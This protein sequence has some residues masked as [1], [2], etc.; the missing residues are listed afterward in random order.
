[1]MLHECERHR[2]LQKH[3]RHD[4]D[5][6][7]ALVEPLRQQLGEAARRASP[8]QADLRQPTQTAECGSFPH[9]SA[10]SSISRPPSRLQIGRIG[11][12]LFD[13]APQSIDQDID[14][15]L[16]CR[17]PRSRQRLARNDRAGIGAEQ[18][19]HLALAFGDADRLVAGAQLSALERECEASEAHDGRL[20]AADRC[21]PRASKHRA[22]PQEQ[23]ARLK[24]LGQIVVDA[25]FQAAYAILRFAARR[26]HQDWHLRPPAQ[27]GGEIEAILA[28]HHDVQHDDVERQSVE[29]PAGLGR[30]RRDRDPMAVLDQVA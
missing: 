18:A 13:L 30:C 10:M 11:G 5:Q 7:R 8:E 6:E 12:V 19:K 3:H 9:R 25:N 4:H 17:A 23:L 15:S 2:G 28:G 24:R 16:L 21:G 29:K 20:G 27:S 26:Q 1:M 14:R 22:D